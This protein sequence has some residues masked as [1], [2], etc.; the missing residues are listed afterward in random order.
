MKFGT[1][2]LTNATYYNGKG[3]AFIHLLDVFQQW[4]NENLPT[5][6]T[7]YEGGGGT[8]TL[9][10]ETLNFLNQLVQ[11]EAKIKSPK[12]LWT[13]FY[14]ALHYFIVEVSP[15]LANKQANQCEHYIENKKL[16]IIR[17]DI[18]NC[19]FFSKKINR[20]FSNELLDAFPVLAFKNN[21]AGHMMALC[22]LQVVLKEEL[23]S[24]Y[25]EV[26]LDFKKIEKQDMHYRKLLSEVVR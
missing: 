13:A 11:V 15:E 19:S 14:S 6:F 16:T 23:F 7:I 24:C 9:A 2:F 18:L 8:G 1:H 17:D 12:K 20:F 4:I 25:D 3:L 22:K 10:F 5:E 21:S 26:N